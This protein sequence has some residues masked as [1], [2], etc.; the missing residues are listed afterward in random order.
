MRV[1]D[2]AVG[3]RVRLGV[4]LLLA[5]GAA[6][7]AL[8]IGSG[9]VHAGRRAGPPLERA[10]LESG[11][12]QRSYG[13]YDPE[14]VGTGKRPLFL[15]LHGGGGDGERQDRISHFTAVAQREG[16]LAV[17]PDGIEKSW[18]DARRTT[19]AG[20]KGIDDV[21]FLGALIDELIQT[22]RADGRRVYV[23]GMSNGGFETQHLV[24]LLSHRIAAAASVVATLPAAEVQGCTLSRAVP[25]AFILGDKDPLVPYEGGQVVR[26]RGEVLS[27][28]ASA[29]FFAQKEACAPQPE[30]TL[31]PD[32]APDDGT[33]IEKRLW[34]GCKGGGEV[35][36]YT[37]QSGGHTWPGG[38]QYLP[39]AIIGKT[40]R[41]LNA[42]EEI[43]RFV[44]R[45]SLP[46]EGVA[47]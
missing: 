45:Y 16:F 25:L 35:A 47:R 12:L 23:T 27:G 43:W 30:V 4:L 18:A 36:L 14:P 9:C 7:V 28:P 5:A 1:R 21:A 24:C 15:A 32:L 20:Q 17:F 19:P 2:A 39:Q 34:K 33:R 3:R 22:R 13:L 31:L 46:E 41:D 8:P 42:S 10:T 29:R 26:S 40:S 38:E 44:S 11:G 37:V 6:A